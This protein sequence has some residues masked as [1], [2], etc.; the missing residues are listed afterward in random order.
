MEMVTRERKYGTCSMRVN[1]TD[2]GFVI[3]VFCSSVFTKVSFDFNVY[4]N[5]ITNAR[6]F[7]FLAFTLASVRL[8]E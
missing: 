7:G 1:E 5:L 8:A 6:L 2:A 3:L 4:N